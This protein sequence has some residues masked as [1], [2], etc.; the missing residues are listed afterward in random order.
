MRSQLTTTKSRSLVSGFTLIELL[1]VISIIAVLLSILLPVLSA[2]REQGKK[3]VCLSNMKQIGMAASAYLN[4]GQD[5][6]PWTYVYMTQPA[7][8]NRHIYY[9]GLS[10]YSSYTWGGMMAARP[11]RGDEHVDFTI[12]PPH[13]RALNKFLAPSART[14][15]NIG[16]V[17]CPGDISS[18]SPVVGSGP[19]TLELESTRASWEAFGTSYSINWYFVED[20][21]LPVWAGP[22]GSGGGGGSGNSGGS[23]NGSEYSEHLYYLGKRVL[24]QTMGGLASTFVIMWENQVDQLLAG[25]VRNGSGKN[26]K[27][28]RGP[29]WHRKFSNHTFLF[30]DGHAQHGYY[31]TSRGFD[32]GWRIWNNRPG[33]EP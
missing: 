9:P 31:D 14:K 12:I 3:L 23:N 16:V 5:N 15:E 30:L 19:V 28:K 17:K 13:L 10:N 25:T 2:S 33:V 1:V 20:P 4:D 24:R 8:P 7:D 18:V 6:L 32:T 11:Y 29:G 27:G 22:G 21:Y 26:G